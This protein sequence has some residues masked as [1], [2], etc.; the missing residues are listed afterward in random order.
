[1]PGITWPDGANAAYSYVKRDIEIKPI[2]QPDSI[3]FIHIH[4]SVTLNNSWTTFSFFERQLFAT[5]GPSFSASAV[6]TAF[7]WFAST[8]IS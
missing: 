8:S 4:D 2:L 7:C 3:P 6:A 5:S 1:V